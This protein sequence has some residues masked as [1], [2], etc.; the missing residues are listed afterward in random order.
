MDIRRE[1]LFELPPAEGNPRN[2]EGDFARLPDGSL[3][4]CWTRYSGSSWDDHEDSTI[5]AVYAHDGL[6]FD[7]SD[8]RTIVRPE[9]V[10]GSN[11]M[12]C[13]LRPNANGGVSLYFLVK[14][15]TKDTA[16]MPVRDEYYRVDSPDGYDF[17]S[18]PTLCFPKDHKGYFAPNN[19]RVITL[20]S[21]RVIVPASEHKWRFDGEKYRIVNS[22][23]ARFFYSDDGGKTFNED[24]QVLL[25]PGENN[26]NGLQEPGVI[27]LPDGRL[28]G[29]FRTDA[30]YQYESFSSDGGV[31][32]TEPRPSRFESPLSPMLISRNPYG[33]KYYAVWN[34][35]KDDPESVEHPRFR[36]TWG[37]TPLAIAESDDGINFGGFQLIESDIHRG[38][39]YPVMFFLSENEALMSYC[40]GGGDIV[41]LQKTTV[42]KITFN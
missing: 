22:G 21:G 29:Y 41:P 28:Y 6:H 23:E 35:Y 4:F 27:E 39:C 26:K 14:F 3:M 17:S 18:E 11:S 32:W 38:Y 37:R 9:R 16:K 42:S 15:D 33:G 25:F 12:S 19:C 1:V 7:T 30:D 10:G 40:S 24:V 2:S 36:N 8:V 34:P 13:T 20:S 5:C 31:S